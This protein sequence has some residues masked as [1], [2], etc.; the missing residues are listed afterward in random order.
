MQ[1]G[2]IP[3]HCHLAEFIGSAPVQ[4]QLFM[5]Q[6]VK[7]MHDGSLHGGEGACVVSDRLN[8]GH[9]VRPPAF[10]GIGLGSDGQNGV[11][12]YIDE[13]DRQCRRADIDG[14]AQ[15]MTG[16]NRGILDGQVDADGKLFN[17][18][19]DTVIAQFDSDFAGR[20]E[21]RQAGQTDAA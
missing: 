2:G 14:D 1:H 20:L 8:S 4:F 5:N 6:T 13:T 9:Y 3:G 11:G 7:L 10:L 15:R 17:W 16:F 18:N 19:G 21:A 12:A